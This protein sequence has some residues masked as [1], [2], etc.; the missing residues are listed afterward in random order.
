MASKSET[1]LPPR[2]R[3]DHEQRTSASRLGA[4]WAPEHLAVNDALSKFESLQKRL[5]EESGKDERWSYH[6]PM[7]RQYLKLG[8][9]AEDFG[10]F[11]TAKELYSELIHS[12]TLEKNKHYHL[13][14]SALDRDSHAITDAIEDLIDQLTILREK[15]AMNISLMKAHLK[16]HAAGPPATEAAAAVTTPGR[17]A[18]EA[19][20]AEPKVADANTQ[21]DDFMAQVAKKKIA[22]Q[23]VLTTNFDD[24]QTALEIFERDEKL[25]KLYDVDYRIAARLE[26]GK[27][28]LDAGDFA[29]ATEI[30]TEAINIL[31]EEK[32]NLPQRR[33]VE[34]WG[35][36][37]QSLDDLINP[38]TKLR[39]QAILGVAHEMMS[40]HGQSAVGGRKR[41]TKKRNTR[42]KN[43]RKRKTRKRNTR[44]RKTKRRN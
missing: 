43:T 31:Q 6:T 24:A 13:N 30:Y 23:P 4:S 36:P 44:K 1:N 29:R 20:P 35:S 41:K 9:N 7:I 39:D 17:V 25:H 27:K 12:L 15:A 10:N 42:K 8:V 32:K 26:L 40:E 14:A 33:K 34:D 3:R 18:A 19:K 2:S 11:T 22:R 16:A 37:F 5:I 21:Y 38:I 28:Y